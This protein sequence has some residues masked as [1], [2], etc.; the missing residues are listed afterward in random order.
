MSAKIETV[1]FNVLCN[2]LRCLAFFASLGGGR[3]LGWG[4]S[5]LQI[6]SNIANRQRG[7]VVRALDL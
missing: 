7:L 2:I 4:A 5:Q 3:G 6:Q 1:L